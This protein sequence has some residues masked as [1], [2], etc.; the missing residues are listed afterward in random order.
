MKTCL[1]ILLFFI[2]G[3]TF[4][5]TDTA[6]QRMIDE[7]KAKASQQ[8]KDT[9]PVKKVVKPLRKDSTFFK[10]TLARKSVPP[11]L[12]DSPSLNVQ[13]TTFQPAQDSSLKQIKTVTAAIDSAKVNVIPWAQDTAFTRLLYLPGL[14]QASKMPLHD[15]ERRNNESKD[16]LFYLFAGLLLFLGIVN[17]AFPGYIKSVFNLLFFQS[18]RYKQSREKTMQDTIPS[19]LLNILFFIVAGLWIT[20]FLEDITLFHFSFTQKIVAAIALV[21][22]IYAIKAIIISLAGALIH[23]REAAN[24]YAT[25]VFNVNKVA[26]LILLPLAILYAYG[27]EYQKS[28]AVSFLVAI[29]ILLI[30]Y[31]FVI[32]FV[33]I[34]GRFKINGLYFFIYLCITEIIPMII[35]IKIL[36]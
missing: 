5:Q 34:T 16:Y 18:H 25:I 10:D 28:L 22:F 12:K 13:D 30:I 26:G 27:S 17:R 6:L 20:F 19:L 4:S 31:R 7:A 35:F 29:C 14:L 23:K 33:D 3:N 36:P 32:S 11:V 1:T 8:K 15:S 24:A 2:A 9:G 21:A